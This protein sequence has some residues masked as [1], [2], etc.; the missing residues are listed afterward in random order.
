VSEVVNTSEPKKVKKKKERER[1]LEEARLRGLTKALMDAEGRRLLWSYLS[2][3]GIYKTSFTSDFGTTAYN[4]GRRSVGLK[5][6]DDIVSA[7]PEFFML[8][9]KENQEDQG[10]DDERSSAND[11]D[12]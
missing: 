6:L 3:C 1:L 5:I 12:E 11:S 4:E 8:M 2:F 9:M 10:D 7:S